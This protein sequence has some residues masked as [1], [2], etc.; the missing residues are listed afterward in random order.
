MKW[1]LLS[2]GQACDNARTRHLYLSISAQKQYSN[3]EKKWQYNL[4]SNQIHN[5]PYRLPLQHGIFV[6]VYLE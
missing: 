4:Q 2:Q 6:A 3:S 1:G 5:Q